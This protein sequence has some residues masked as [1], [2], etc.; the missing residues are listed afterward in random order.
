M[1][2]GSSI[3]W[4]GRRHVFEGLD[5]ITVAAPPAGHIDHLFAEH[6]FVFHTQL[7][8]DREMVKRPGPAVHYDVESGEVAA[9]GTSI[10]GWGHAPEGSPRVLAK[11]SL[12]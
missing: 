1:P 11:V 7:S 2:L 5:C 8:T 12:R 9:G 3:R 6:L 4:S 10:T